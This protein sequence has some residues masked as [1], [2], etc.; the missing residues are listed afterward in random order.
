MGGIE[1][2]ASGCFFS[3]VI[4]CRSTISNQPASVDL[5]ARKTSNNLQSRIRLPTKRRVYSVCYALRSEQTLSNI[6]RE[7]VTGG[8]KMRKNSRILTIF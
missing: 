7:F 3:C 8:F 2:N 5:T 6:V 4:K 1:E